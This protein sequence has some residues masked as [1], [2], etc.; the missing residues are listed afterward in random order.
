MLF[1][2]TGQTD[3]RDQPACYS[4]GTRFLFQAVNW[5]GHEVYRSPP[6]S[7][8]VKCDWVC[9]TAISLHGL[10]SDN[11]TFCFSLCRT[12]LKNQD[13]TLLLKIAGVTGGG[14]G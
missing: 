11:L 8:E 4:K 3:F 10:D 12:K 7:V 2:K 14:L 9:T 13:L 1:S 6:F 5:P